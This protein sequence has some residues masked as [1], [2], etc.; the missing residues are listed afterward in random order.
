MSI[1]SALLVPWAPAQSP[2]FIGVAAED[3]G[4]FPQRRESLRGTRAPQ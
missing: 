2:A 4:E 1:V 3:V